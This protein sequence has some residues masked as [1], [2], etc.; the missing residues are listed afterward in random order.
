MGIFGNKPNTE[1]EASTAEKPADTSTEPEATPAVEPAGEPEA[2]EQG[3]D[4]SP[5]DRDLLAEISAAA[6]AVDAEPEATQVQGFTAPQLEQAHLSNA[7]R[8]AYDLH[9]AGQTLSKKQR[10]AYD[11]ALVK[12]TALTAEPEASTPTAEP[13][14]PAPA[15]GSHAPAQPTT[16]EPVMIGPYNVKPW[17]DA[18]AATPFTFECPPLNVAVYDDGTYGDADTLPPAGR[19]VVDVVTLAACV[20]AQQAMAQHSHGARQINLA[21]AMTFRPDAG[22]YTAGQWALVRQFVL[23]GGDPANGLG[24]AADP[25]LNQTVASTAKIVEAKL[26]VPVKGNALNG[27]TSWRNNIAPEGL[28]RITPAFAGANAPA[29]PLWFTHGGSFAAVKAAHDKAA[30]KAAHKAQ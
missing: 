20:L 3:N 27:R 12:L 8:K 24:G 7:E 21:Q 18:M 5:V 10:K 2:G 23:S 16:A 1:P 29:L 11:A 17:L 19:T 26:V 13:E 4:G 14:A 9:T 6:D 25:K 22:L 28:R 15:Q 30:R